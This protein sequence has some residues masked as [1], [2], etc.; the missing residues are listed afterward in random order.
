MIMHVH[1]LTHFLARHCT[2]APLMHADP[3]D[4]EQKRSDPRDLRTAAKAA[5]WTMMRALLRRMPV[6]QINSGASKDEGDPEEQ[7]A[8]VCMLCCQA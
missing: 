4:K 5:D 2:V 6:V 7:G 1:L 3:Q 8:C